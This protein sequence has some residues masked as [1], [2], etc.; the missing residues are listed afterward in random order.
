MLTKLATIAL[1]GASLVAASACR[2]RK[3]PGGACD[4]AA[5]NGV[6]AMIKQSR[7]RIEDAQ[8]PDDIK[9]QIVDR[10]KRVE[11]AGARMR[12][13]FASRCVDDKW[14]PDV[15]S[16]FVTGTT[17]DEMRA[18]RTKL[19]PAQHAALQTAELEL[20]AGGEV[21]PPVAASTELPVRSG[22]GSADP[23]LAMIERAI[24]D[25]QE[26]VAKAT[27]DSE[28]QQAREQLLALEAERKV[29]EI[30]IYAVHPGPPLTQARIDRLRKELESVDAKIKDTEARVA[31]AT[32]QA[33]RDHAMQVLDAL[34]S[35][36]A[37]KERELAG[38]P[39]APGAAASP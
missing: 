38:A 28:R 30:Q 13:V 18:C 5:R 37:A 7:A 29:L 25:A 34:R 1:L 16:C 35:S 2:Q 4:A 19:T 17:L 31:E 12:A 15:V 36:K 11:D 8:L 21:T 14:A 9:K 24:A 39:A 6:D 3:D 32:T 10:Q 33:D 20:L 23:R 27:D 22:V 26:A